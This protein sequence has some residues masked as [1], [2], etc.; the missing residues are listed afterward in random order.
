MGF[1]K[2]I[3]L[4]GILAFI[5][6]IT[7]KAQFKGSN[8][9]EFQYGKLPGDTAALSALYDRAV[10]GYYYKSFKASMALEQFYSPFRD[11][12]YTKITQFSLQYDSDPLQVKIGNFYETI[13]RGLLLRSFEIPGAI[14]EDLSYRSRHYF[15]H[16]ILG[17]VTKFRHKNFTTKLIYGRPLSYV[18]P[19]NQDFKTRRPDE[20][21]A[22]YS[23]YSFKGQT[24]GASVLSLKNSNRNSVYAMTTA[25]GKVSS[26]VSY[27]AEF[28]KNI[29]DYTLSDFSDQSPYA[30]YGSINLVFEKTGISAEYKN[31]NNF[32]LGS[33][34]NEPPALVKEYT[35]K[36]LNRS[37]HVL[38]PLNE[39]GSQVEVY[40]TF[41]D[42]STLTFNNTIAI[43]DFDKRYVFQEYFA[44]YDFTLNDKHE[45]KLFADYAEDPFTLQQQRISAGSYF[46]W[47]VFKSSSL[48]TEYE[49]QTFKRSGENVQNQVLTLGYAWKSKIIGNIIGEYS[50]D[51]FLIEKGT[52]RLWIGANLKYQINAKNSVQLFAGQRRGGPACNA[53]ICYEVLDFKGV[54]VR[55]TSRF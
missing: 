26:V 13:G 10:A 55:I 52:S 43:N 42:L 30:F 54:E 21:A 4:F 18:F 51:P 32:L 2:N 29:D 48:K 3:L 8:L 23:D 9:M 25:S 37:T 16:D 27:Y 31:Y 35:Y 11:R 14:L 6:G 20:I 36:V 39:K 15:N 38:Q 45:V 50:T 28:A 41:A 40:Y 12:N 24:F 22:I 34:I 17:I 53:G 7:L 33:G 46:E 19:P 1:Q 5:P 44:E 47:K 49:F